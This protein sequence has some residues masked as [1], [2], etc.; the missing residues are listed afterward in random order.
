M[1]KFNLKIEYNGQRF[2]MR[3]RMV[4]NRGT[5]TTFLW[6]CLVPHY[7]LIPVHPGLPGLLRAMSHIQEGVDQL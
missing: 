4:Q 2:G 3:G 7:I 5:Q 1:G 6:N